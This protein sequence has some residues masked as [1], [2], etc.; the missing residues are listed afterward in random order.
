MSF[1]K[2]S[3]SV[4]K[5][6]GGCALGLIPYMEQINSKLA[7]TQLN[8]PQVTPQFHSL[9]SHGIRERGDFIIYKNNFCLYSKPNE[10]GQRELV[11]VKKCPQ[12]TSRTQLIFEELQ[13]L[14]WP[15]EKGSIRF[16]EAP[17]NSNFKAGLWLDF[18]NLD[19]KI[20]LTAKELI[21]SLLENNFYIEVGQKQKRV[22]SVAGQLKLVE[23]EYF[24]WSVTYYEGKEVGLFSSVSSFTQ[25]GSVAS[26]KFATLLQE[27]LSQIQAQSIVEFGSG[28]GTLTIPTLAQGRRVKCCEFEETALVSL[29]KTIE[30]YNKKYLFSDRVSFLSGNFHKLQSK[31][32]FKDSDTIL[33]NPPR[34]GIGDF[35]KSLDQ[36]ERNQRPLYLIY[37]SCFIESMKKDSIILDQLGYQL[38]KLDVIDQFPQSHHFELLGLWRIN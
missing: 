13:T 3:C 8:F 4:L 36:I 16:R 22:I 10:N 2:F 18:A 1:E 9:G 24:P 14:N 28:I 17:A 35:L 27:V 5:E 20:L 26:L 37:M 15:I 29:K 25:T 11:A 19:I 7:L 30:Y 33:V 32:L 38:Q 31:D 21:T 34:S 23:P 6:C 12:L